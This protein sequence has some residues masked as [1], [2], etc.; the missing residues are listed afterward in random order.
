[1]RAMTLFMVSLALLGGCTTYGV[2]VTDLSVPS[3][4]DVAGVREVDLATTVDGDFNTAGSSA[5]NAVKA[6]LHVRMI[7]DP[8]TQPPPVGVNW[9]LNGDV[10]TAQP[11]VGP[12]SEELSFRGVDLEVPEALDVNLSSD[13][14]STHMKVAGVHGHVTVTTKASLE[15]DDVGPMDITTEG[16]ISGSIDAPGTI[17]A[18]N[19]ELTLTG[20]DYDRIDIKT[21]ANTTLHVP[22][23]QDWFFDLTS[24][25]TTQG[26]S[27]T[28]GG[29]MVVPTG[30]LTM[31][32]GGGPTIHVEA[33]GSVT[34]TDQ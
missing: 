1:M 23:G 10:L 24:A 29:A 19:L 18:D 17:Q 15:L 22:P 5:T 20:T 27:I 28:L 14:D 12:P 30:E 16:A 13:S 7:A 31:I 21:K 32:G 2:A 34:I 3:D 6:T 11:D 26:V 4:H 9:E 8:A 33:G 25:D